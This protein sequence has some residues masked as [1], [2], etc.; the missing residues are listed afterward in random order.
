MADLAAFEARLCT[1]QRIA[2]AKFDALPIKAPS[3][4]TFR[5]FIMQFPGIISK[6]SNHD[7]VAKSFENAG[8]VPP[9]LAKILGP[10][11]GLYLLSPADVN[12][13]YRA[14]KGPFLN[15]FAVFGK[16]PEKMIAKELPFLGLKHVI[17]ESAFI[18]EAA[19]LNRGNSLDLLNQHVIADEFQRIQALRAEAALAK[20][21]IALRKAA[22]E[23]KR[24]ETVYLLLYFEKFIYIYILLCTLFKFVC[25]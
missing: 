20:A 21:A 6:L 24:R 10:W 18:D 5:R 4:R 3:K 1:E 19:K 17:R 16:L 8:L 25:K 15:H 12:R 22:A 23:D 9:C 14:I 13:L 2:L 11:P 7:V